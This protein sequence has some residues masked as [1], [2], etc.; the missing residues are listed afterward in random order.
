MSAT[1]NGIRYRN[2][3]RSG[4]HRKEIIEAR[5]TIPAKNAAGSW[6]PWSSSRQAA[7]FYE[8]KTERLDLREHPVQGGLVREHA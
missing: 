8:F 3:S 5:T 7:D 1:R 2:A 4:E 6:A